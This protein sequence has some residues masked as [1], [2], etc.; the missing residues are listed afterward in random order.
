MEANFSETTNTV[1]LRPTC[2]TVLCILTFIGSGWGIYKGISGY[3]SAD[4]AAG[5]VAEAQNKIDDQM[6]GQDQ[7]AFY[8]NMMGNMFSSMSPSNIRK[9][10]IVMLVSSLLTL[11]G[12][13]LMWGLRKIGYYLYIAGILVSIFVPMAIFHGG[14]M[15]IMVGGISA[16]FGIIFIILYGVNVKYLV[17]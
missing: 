17:R 15:G 6:G 14:M 9:S 2:L 16:F 1:S 3:Y 10:S 13:L 12:A 8:K 5:I 4:T 7:P 11:A